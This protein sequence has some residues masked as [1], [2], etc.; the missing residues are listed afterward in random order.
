MKADQQDPATLKWITADE[1][2]C[3]ISKEETLSDH[4]MVLLKL[5]G[6]VLFNYIATL[7]LLVSGESGM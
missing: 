2:N 7:T 6:L 4:F 1:F 5:C 3:D